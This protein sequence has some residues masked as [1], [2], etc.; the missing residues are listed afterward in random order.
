MVDKH[1]WMSTIIIWV[2]D[3]LLFPGV[4]KY[5]DNEKLCCEVI[6]VIPL[7][8]SYD[9]RLLACQERGSWM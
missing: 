4:D 6:M 3:L 8:S 9:T 1:I 5:A 2:C 7:S